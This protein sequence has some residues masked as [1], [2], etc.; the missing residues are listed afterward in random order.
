MADP[1][2]G[3]E[4]QRTRA[5]LLPEAYGRPCPRCGL[6]MLRGQDLDLGHSTDLA[7]DPQAKGDRIEHA[8]CNRRAGQELSTRRAKFQPSRDW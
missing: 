2:Y 4:H 8:A 3:I 7:F 5:L 1:A 6:P